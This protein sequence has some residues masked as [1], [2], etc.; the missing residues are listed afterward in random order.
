MEEKNKM[1]GFNALKYL[2]TIVAVLSR[3]FHDRELLLG[4]T[5][6]ISLKTVTWATSGIATVYNT[7][8]DIV[9]DWGLLQRSSKNAWLRD[10]LLI[11]E[12]SV[13]FLAIVSL[14]SLFVSPI[15]LN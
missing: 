3:T 8:W 2:S 9:V 6:G 4:R 14:D 13:Y 5:P 11:P 7:Y 15:D 10:K 1:E 12:K